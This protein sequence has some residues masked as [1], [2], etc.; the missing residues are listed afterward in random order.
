MPATSSASLVAA[1]GEA[2]LSPSPLSRFGEK[3]TEDDEYAEYWAGNGAGWDHD[4]ETETSSLRLRPGVEG[5]ENTIKHK[6]RK[7]FTD[8]MVVVQHMAR[9]INMLK[10]QTF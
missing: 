5:R 1:A 7:K 2:I 6:K 9:K 8:K 4:T 3:I 10:P